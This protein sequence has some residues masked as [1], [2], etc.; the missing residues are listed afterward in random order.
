MK[1]SRRLKKRA[2]EQYK[3]FKEDEKKNRKRRSKEASKWFDEV[4]NEKSR[5][6]KNSTWLEKKIESNPLVDDDFYKLIKGVNSPVVGGMYFFK[7]PDPKY[8]ETLAHY[9]ALPLV[10]PMEYYDNGF[11]GLNIHYL[12]PKER[13]KFIAWL[14]AG[15]L[16][17]KS[18]KEFYK[19]SYQIF[20]TIAN[21]GNYKKM[22]KRYLYNR[23]KDSYVYIPP[24]EVETVIF[25]NIEDF[26]KQSAQTVWRT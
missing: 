5:F 22:I 8:K 25:F 2:L 14:N 10:F 6:K 3:R 21:T 15:Y 16:E 11:L 19:I 13:M 18:G 26:K 4:V 17:S 12:H 1:N 24:S 9:D 7:Y 20:K 23:V